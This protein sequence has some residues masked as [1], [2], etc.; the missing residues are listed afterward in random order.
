VQ[1]HQVLTSFNSV[2]GY[3]TTSKWQYCA[4]AICGIDHAG[5]KKKKKKKR[6]KKE[7]EKHCLAVCIVVIL[8][9]QS[10]VLSRDSNIQKVNC[11]YVFCF[12]NSSYF[13][14]ST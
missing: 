11:N 10:A 1:L 2:L 14:V 4:R 12:Y 8:F 6:K 13:S 3:D 7:K 5:K 9:V